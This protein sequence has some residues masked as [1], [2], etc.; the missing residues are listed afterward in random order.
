MVFGSLRDYI[1]GKGKITHTSIYYTFI[2]EGF[3]ILSSKKLAV[4]RRE[5]LI[6]L[7]ENNIGWLEKCFSIYKV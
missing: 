2:M 6:A 5:P 4:S 3:Q 1:Y 7:D